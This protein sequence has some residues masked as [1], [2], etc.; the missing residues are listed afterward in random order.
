MQMCIRSVCLITTK[1]IY[2]SIKQGMIKNE[3]E[4]IKKELLNGFIDPIP[5]NAIKNFVLNGSKFIR[6]TL[7]IYYLRSQNCIISD[8]I[9]K[10]LIA[11]EIIHN[12]SLLHDDVIDEAEFRRNKTTL[13]KEFSPKISILAGD[14]LLSYAT[15]KIL[16]IKNT[17][18][19]E[20]FISCT[21]EMS[22]AE[23]KQYFASGKIPTKYEYL[24]ICKGKTASL[25]SATLQACAILTNLD[26]KKA[27]NF[28]ELFG[29]CFQIKNDL[30][31]TSA[32]ED[33]KNKIYTAKDI[34]G[35]EN[36]ELLLDNYKIEL[37]EIIKNFSEN[38]YKKG[39]E[40][41]INSL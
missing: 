26:L 22:Y 40:G 31:T 11:T 7:A 20:L 41:L 32:L 17:E 5:N 10:I 37:R 23:I 34:L 4:K 2:D 24:K 8:D 21:T 33:K 14:Y 39:L 9:Y 38:N 3:L 27:K 35:I 25:F 28:A 18:I 15:K 19:L 12:A 29:I 6:S 1:Y 16:E 36:T 30:D 13:A